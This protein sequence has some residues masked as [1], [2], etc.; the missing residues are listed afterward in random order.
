MKIYLVSVIYAY[1]D[2][3]MS[4]R[5]EVFE[6]K[7][8]AK[9]YFNEFKQAVIDDLLEL[10][11]LEDVDELFNYYEETYDYDTLWGYLAPDCTVELELEI[12]ELDLL[13]WK[14]N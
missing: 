1:P 7:D 8:S 3:R 2:E 12:E 10:E 14:E 13:T 11:D 5:F 4:K 9:K 6:D